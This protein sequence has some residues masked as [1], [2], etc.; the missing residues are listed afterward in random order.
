MDEYG[1]RIC[2][3]LRR[4]GSSVDWSRLAFTMSD[5]L[6]VAVREAFV[7]LHAKQLIYRDNRIVNWDCTL[8]SAVSDI[9]VTQGSQTWG[10]GVGNAQR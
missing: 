5:Q 4:M 10:G 1:G 8:Q 7:L 2:N 9:E 6:S 3:Q